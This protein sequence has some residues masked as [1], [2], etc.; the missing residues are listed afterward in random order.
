MAQ[1]SRLAFI[2]L[3]LE[4]SGTSLVPGSQ[5][6]AMGP[7][8]LPKH[9]HPGPAETSYSALPAHQQAQNLCIVF[10]AFL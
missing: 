10:A 1:K 3:C 9:I 6:G 5:K 4:R 7:I 2:L 8:Q